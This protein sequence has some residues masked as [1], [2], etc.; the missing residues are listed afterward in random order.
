MERRLRLQY[1]EEL[2][3]REYVGEIPV[4]YPDRILKFMLCFGMGSLMGH[5]ED[6]VPS[7]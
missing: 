4:G 6:L 1:V 3:P 2:E 5:V 7:L